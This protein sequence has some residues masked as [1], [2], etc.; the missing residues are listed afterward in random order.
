MNEPER[1]RPMAYDEVVDHYFMEHRA[2][3]IDLAAFLDRLDR[4]D[5]SEAASDFRVSALRRSIALLLDGQP[6]RARRVL[7]LF[8][9]HTDA[10][11][12]DAQGTKGALGA[13]DLDHGEGGSA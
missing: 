4:S 1:P 13:V 3:V 11:A 5:G 10:L 2:K 8:S 7:E 12:Q 9:D 6:Q